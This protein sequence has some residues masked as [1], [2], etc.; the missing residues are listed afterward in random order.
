MVKHCFLVILTVVLIQ[1]AAGAFSQVS[2]ETDTDKKQVRVGEVLRLKVILTQQATNQGPV[3]ETTTIPNLPSIPGFAVI[4]AQSSQQVSMVQNVTQVKS[5]QEYQLVAEKD[6]RH[7]IPP[8]VHR[9]TDPQ[10]GH[11]VELQSKPIEVEV[12]PSGAGGSWLLWSLGLGLIG[13]GGLATFLVMRRSHPTPMLETT[14]AGETAEPPELR[15]LRFFLETRQAEGFYGAASDAVRSLLEK[16]Y[17]VPA[18]S[19]TTGELLAALRDR[20]VEEGTIDWVRMCLE[21]C[22]L[23]KF[24]GYAST[25]EEMQE[26]IQGLQQRL[27]PPADKI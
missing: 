8:I 1:V 17:R 24:A 23:A 16:Q 26:M 5:I 10:T 27:V 14:P 25:A 12:L 2:I 13:A 22:D 3:M 21:R 15:R 19:L 11:P 6:G 18:Q 7:T 4:A 9:Y 20:K